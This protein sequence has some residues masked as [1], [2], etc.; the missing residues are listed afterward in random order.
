MGLSRRAVLGGI[1]GAGATVGGLSTAGKLSMAATKSA[2]ATTACAPSAK[3]NQGLDIP[4][5]LLSVGIDGNAHPDVYSGRIDTQ[6]PPWIDRPSVLTELDLRT[7]KIKQT[8]LPI[9]SAHSVTPLPDGSL[10]I[11]AHHKPV[12]IHVTADHAIIKTYLAEDGY[13]YGGHSYYIPSLNLLAVPSRRD[14]PRTKADTGLIQFY[15]VS[16]M[17]LVK[18]VDSKGIHPHELRLLPQDDSQMLITHYG[19]VHTPHPQGLADHVIE[20]KLSIMDLNKFEI[21]KEVHQSIDAIYTHMDVGY[22]GDAYVVSNQFFPV[23]GLSTKQIADGVKR[24]NIPTEIARHPT[25]LVKRRFSIPS[26]LIKTDPITGKNEVLMTKP[27][28]VMRSQS[29]AAHHASKRVFATYAF[30]N[31]VLVHD[32]GANETF[33]QD[34]FEYGLHEIRGVTAIPNTD[35]IAFNDLYNGIAIVNAYTMELV[36]NFTARTLKAPHIFAVV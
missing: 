18:Q 36:G 27:G 33:S 4:A 20:P 1:I 26:G 34:A 7:G 14:N 3:T 31:R 24:F 13:V 5:K 11:A 6:E 32:E 9:Q 30:S 28:D 23:R 10:F 25:S 16:N 35:Y 12:S 21:V 2:D 22:K 8:L 29:V 15:D 19:D 17:E